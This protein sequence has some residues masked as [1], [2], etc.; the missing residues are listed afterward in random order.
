MK[1]SSK[2]R[3]I[4]SISAF[5][6]LLT[7]C[8]STPTPTPH[9]SHTVSLPPNPPEL[10]A[11]VMLVGMDSLSHCEFKGNVAASSKL[12]EKG[13]HPPFTER[14]ISARDDLRAKT[15]QL[16]GDTVQVTRTTNTGRFVIPENKAVTMDGKAY[17]CNNP[18]K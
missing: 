14:L 13:E 8:A 4:I 5:T 6:L 2:F 12:N 18:K 15:H 16:G 3:G 17:F 9:D 10:Q 7:A 1:V 11:I